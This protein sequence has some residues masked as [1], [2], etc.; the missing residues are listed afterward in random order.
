MDHFSYT[1]GY[2]FDYMNNEDLLIL[3]S[4]PS[5]GPEALERSGLTHADTN[6]C[7]QARTHTY[8]R[9]NISKQAH[10]ALQAFASSCASRLQAKSRAR[11]C[12]R[13]ADCE[14]VWVRK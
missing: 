5:R 6:V 7:K 3:Q 14:H 12:A 11:V 1:Y 4:R 2:S 9:K 8:A 13:N 10:Q